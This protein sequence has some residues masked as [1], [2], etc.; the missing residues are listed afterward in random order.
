MTFEIE[1]FF[2][3]LGHKENVIYY[4]LKGIYFEY[5]NELNSKSKTQE[6]NYTWISI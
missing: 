3:K 5:Q 2:S 4:N 6:K 1:V